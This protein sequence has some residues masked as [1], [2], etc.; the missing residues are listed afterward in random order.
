MLPR[1]TGRWTEQGAVDAVRQWAAAHGGQSP[2]TTDFAS[3]PAL[4][5][6][7]YV[8]RH[9]GGLASL[10]T[11][12]G[13]APGASGYGGRRRPACARLPVGRDAPSPKALGE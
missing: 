5:S 4:P 2:S 13:L 1:R 10:R 12:A 8:V 9:F 3:D 7:T 11:R 6:R